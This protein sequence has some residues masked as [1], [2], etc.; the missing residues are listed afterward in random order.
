M[1]GSNTHGNSDYVCEACKKTQRERGSSVGGGILGDKLEAY[2]RVRNQDQL[3][4]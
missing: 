3:I 1:P 2:L 4:S